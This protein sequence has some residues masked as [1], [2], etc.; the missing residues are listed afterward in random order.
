MTTPYIGEIQLFGFN[1]NPQGW[2]FCNGASIPIAQ[3]TAL[4]SLLGSA[5]GGDGNT[6]FQLP[7]LDGRAVCGLG[8][9]PGLTPRT[10][11]Q[12][13]GENTVTLTPSQMGAHSHTLYAWSHPDP[14]RRTPSAGANGGLAFLDANPAA[15]SFAAG[16]PDTQFHGGMVQPA[17]PPTLVAH[18]NRQPYL[19]LNFCIALEG[20]YP[21]FA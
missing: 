19:T 17:G 12:A 14:A 10:L 13:F 11:G 18:E 20:V 7:R 4:F 15:K 8:N 2:A 6:F 16:A 1:F 21:N 3:N 5:F 9:G